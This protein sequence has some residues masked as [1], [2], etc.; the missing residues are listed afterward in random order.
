MGVGPSNSDCRIRV[1]TTASCADPM[2]G[3]VS[4]AERRGG[5]TRQACFGKANIGEPLMT[6]RKGLQTLS[7]PRAGPHSCNKAQRQPADW[8]GGNRYLGGAIPMTDCCAERGNQCPDAG[9]K[10]RLNLS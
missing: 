6:Y 10:I 5:S 2:V 4:V 3:V 8:L 7:K 1:Q 9:M